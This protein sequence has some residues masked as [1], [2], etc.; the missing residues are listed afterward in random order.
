MVESKCW[1]TPQ[2]YLLT[3]IRKDTMPISLKPVISTLLKYHWSINIWGKHAQIS[4]K[5]RMDQW[6]EGLLLSNFSTAF[7]YIHHPTILANI[8][9]NGVLQTIIK[10]Y[11]GFLNTIIIYLFHNNE[12]PYS[13]LVNRNWNLYL[14][15]ELTNY[16]AM[17]ILC[18]YSYIHILE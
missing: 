13:A 9:A 16:M 7:D 14:V 17:E 8:W 11:E 12:I 1:S 6:E 10:W 5:H 2:D 3:D 15:Q 4:I 18:L